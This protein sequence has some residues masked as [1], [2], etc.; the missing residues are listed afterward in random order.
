M[1]KENKIRKKISNYF[2]KLVKLVAKEN[3]KKFCYNC[4]KVSNEERD[5]CCSSDAV[6]TT[7]KE[8]IAYLYSF[9]QFKQNTMSKETLDL[10]ERLIKAINSG[11]TN[12]NYWLN[13]YT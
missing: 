5:L 3:H 7:L 12:G 4:S 9:K 2:W 11:I 6:E 10:F 1:K 8:F 13:S